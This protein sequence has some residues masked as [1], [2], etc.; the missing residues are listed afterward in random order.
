MNWN[1]IVAIV[2]WFTVGIPP[3][4]HRNDRIG[5]RTEGFGRRKDHKGAL[6]PMP[7]KKECKPDLLDDDLKG[8]ASE[9]DEFIKG[10]KN[11]KPRRPQPKGKNLDRKQGFLLDHDTGTMLKGT[12][13][14]TKF[15]LEYIQKGKWHQ[16]L[17]RHSNFVW[18]DDDDSDNTSKPNKRRAKKSAGKFGTFDWDD[19]D[20]IEILNN[21]RRQARVRATFENN[22]EP[23]QRF[24]QEELDFLY[25]LSK[26]LWEDLK[27]RHPDYDPEDLLPFNVSGEVKKDWT[28]RFN[29]RFEGRVIPPNTKPIRHRNTNALMTQRHRYKKLQEDFKL[30][31]PKPR[32]KRERR[33]DEEEEEEEEEGGEWSDGDPGPSKRSKK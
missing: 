12:S 6:R 7:T 10:G 16:N 1:L 4:R 15:S 30:T 19:Q 20:H 18:S 9:P 33:E 23:S 14:P 13:K 11:I 2:R 32:G 5:A 27:Q 22:R 28:E 24:S 25:Q 8:W 26:E 29:K 21:W 3:R 17:F 31:E